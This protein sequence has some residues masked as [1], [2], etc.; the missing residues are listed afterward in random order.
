MAGQATAVS[1]QTGKI[2]TANGTS[3][4]SPV[5]AGMVACLWQALPTK[6]NKKRQI[7]IASADRFTSPDN[8]YG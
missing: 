2:T 5:L 1:N 3:F 8:Q 7:I 6:T 4:S